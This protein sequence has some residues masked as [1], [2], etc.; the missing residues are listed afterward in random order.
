M[1]SRG[2]HW[3]SVPPNSALER[4]RLNPACSVD[5]LHVSSQGRFGD[6]YY[7]HVGHLLVL[8]SMIMSVFF[9]FFLIACLCSFGNTFNIHF[10][11]T[12]SS[13]PIPSRQQEGQG[14]PVRTV[15]PP[16]P[17]CGG[18]TPTGTLCAMPVDCTTSCT[19]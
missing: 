9:F 6:P 13:L 10:R 1:I 11:F 3:L 5:W 19:M 4:N 16:L 14:R 15:R 8:I 2:W 7:F 18:G 12:L 17:R